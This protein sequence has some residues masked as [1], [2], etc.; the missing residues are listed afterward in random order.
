[1]VSPAFTSLD[2]R[3]LLE[4]GEEPFGVIR[5]RVDALRPHEGLTLIAPFLPAPLIELLKGEGYAVEI[6][7]RRPDEWRVKFWRDSAAQS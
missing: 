1:M 3:E 6:E 5:A 2:I 4:Q 7:R